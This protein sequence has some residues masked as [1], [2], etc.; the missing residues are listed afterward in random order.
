MLAA[1]ATVY[2][3]TAWS[4]DSPVLRRALRG[5]CFRGPTLGGAL[6]L[7]AATVAILWLLGAELLSGAAVFFGGMIF[8]FG[9]AGLLFL[10]LVVED[11]RDIFSALAGK[12]YAYRPFESWQ[13]ADT[14]SAT[15]QCLPQPNC[16][17]QQR[18]CGSEPQPC[19]AGVSRPWRTADWQRSHQR[20]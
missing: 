11:L 16:R 5:R 7:A 13:Q 12:L 20:R 9:G 15:N 2:R 4:L 8:L 1:V 10:D 19:G 18:R 6:L 17:H 3:V 14:S